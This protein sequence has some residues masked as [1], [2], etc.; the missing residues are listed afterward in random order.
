M[1]SYLQESEVSVDL[2][3]DVLLDV[4]REACRHIEIRDSIRDIA[5][6]LSK[7]LPVSA[8]LVRRID[9]QH[10]CLDTVAVGQSHAAPFFVSPKSECSEAKLKRLVAWAGT[11]EVLHGQRIKRTGELALAVPPEIEGEVLVGPLLG[12]EGPAGVLVVVA[13]HLKSFKAQHLKMVASLLEPFS[14]ALEND[15]RLHELALLREA[16]EADRSSLLTRLGRQDLNE[17]VVGADRGLK[18]VMERVELVSQSDVPVLIL[19]E[20]GTGKEVVSRAI[21]HRSPRGNGPFIRVNCGAIPPELIDSQLFGHE[22]GSFTG[23]SDLRQGWFE[24][25]D[26]GTLFLDEI[27]ELP[28]PAQVRL[29]RVLQEGEIERVGGQ[30]PI[31]VD[32]RIVAATHRDLASM[33]KA[34]TFRE[35]L[36]YRVAIF[37]ILLPRLKERLEDIPA[38]ARHFAQRA[39]NRFGLAYVEPSLSDLQL[40]LNYSWPGNIRELGA[41]IDR[42]AILGDGKSL[43]VA[44]SLGLAGTSPAPA[45]AEGPTLFEVTTEAYRPLVPAPLVTSERTSEPVETLNAAMKRH[46]EKALALTRGRVEGKQ[47]A[48]KILG[49][50]P[51]TLRARMRKL[52]IEWSNYREGL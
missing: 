51:H 10:L 2:F 22:K 44:K 9:R 47:G 25:A 50:N 6:L 33:V 27:G 30:Q 45:I 15:R 49:I 43:E 34:G 18:Q 38:L 5:P 13:E 17:P 19:G 24:R 32:V 46:I 4:W 37:P 48:A 35:D 1:P 3:R 40:L 16:A 28:L 41:V 52:Q 12:H 23:A 11:G 42:A 21:H 14:A 29:L 8:L 31:R 26:G 36:W 20:T 39:A 7:H